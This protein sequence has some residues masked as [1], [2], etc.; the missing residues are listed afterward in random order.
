MKLL[1]STISPINFNSL[2]LIC[3]CTEKILGSAD[4][5]LS[6]T[7]EQ[8]FFDSIHAFFLLLLVQE[9]ESIF[10]W[11]GISCPVTFLC[12]SKHNRYTHEQEFVFADYLDVDFYLDLKQHNASIPRLYP[13]QLC[14]NLIYRS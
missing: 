1:V 10:D 8:H 3:E 9:R 12:I 4:V 2:F 13:F 6:D 7:S 14:L 11:K 5:P